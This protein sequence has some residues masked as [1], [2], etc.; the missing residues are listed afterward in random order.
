MKKAAR[1]SRVLCRLKEVT[2]E[3]ADTTAEAMPEQQ[4]A[5][6]EVCSSCL[7]LCLCA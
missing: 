3:T 1:C 4:L 7:G 5:E 6:A 2:E